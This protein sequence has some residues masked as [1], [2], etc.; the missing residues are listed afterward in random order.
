MYVLFCVFCFIVSFCVL[1][2]CKCVLYYC[3]RVSNQLQLTNISNSVSIKSKFQ[4]VSRIYICICM[5]VYIYIYSKR[6]GLPRQAEL[7]QG[8]PGRLRPRISWRFGTTRVVVR[9]PKAPADFTP[10]E[11]PGTHFTGWVDLR[12]HGSFEGTSDTTGNRSQNLPTS[13]AVP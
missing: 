6:K 3:H 12:A 4:H 8:V 11:I 10:G 7:A 1:F 2:V 9:Q 13:S 5:Y